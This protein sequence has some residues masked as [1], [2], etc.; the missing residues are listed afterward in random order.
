MGRSGKGETLSLLRVE[1]NQTTDVG[2]ITP[3]LGGDGYRYDPLPAAMTS[4]ARA[5]QASPGRTCW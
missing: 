2:S 5:D 4:R 1:A 3:H